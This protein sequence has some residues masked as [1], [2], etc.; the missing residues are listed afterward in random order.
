MGSTISLLLPSRGR[1]KQL[2]RLFDSILKKTSNLSNVEIF[3]YLDEDDAHNYNLP[4]GSINLKKIVGPRMTMGAYNTACLKRSTNDVVILLNDDMVIHT[5]GWDRI[6]LDL[7][8]NIEDG[9]YL[10]YANDMYKKS[11]FCTIPILSR[12][13]AELLLDPYPELYKGAFLDVHLFDIF[14]RLAKTGHERI[15]Y[16][17]NV[18][19]EHLH[20]RA[21]KADM[22]ETYRHRD[23]FGDD[24]TFILLSE[25]R[26]V[27]AGRLEAAITG[28]ELPELPKLRI[29]H[30]IS[31]GAKTALV[32]YSKTFLFDSTLPVMWRLQLFIWFLGRYIVGKGYLGKV[33]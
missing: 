20:Y 23:R 16:M 32:T 1:P 10:A 14:K 27:S 7:H 31:N 11:R 29:S 24:E 12:K 5:D 22:D 8:N 26:R 33:A 9:I 19:F 13:T 3:L 30:H 25:M 4:N 18:V 17:E 15:Y 28:G 6:I 21:G 2:K